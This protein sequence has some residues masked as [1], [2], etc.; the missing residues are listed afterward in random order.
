MHCI[1]CSII[2]KEI[3]SEIIYEDNYTIAF[4]DIA[5]ISSGHVLVI[6]KLHFTNL[7][8]TDPLML[9]Y[10]MQSAQKIAGA[11]AKALKLSGYNILINNGAVAGQ[12][13]DH[14]HLHIIPR[15]A[16]DGL[17]AWPQ[18]EYQASEAGQISKKIIASLPKS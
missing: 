14:F 13:I 11:M 17:E 15:R 6:P 12:I 10:V 8:E 5:P 4:L 16:K 7:T 3:K 9:A 2:K 1:F 18:G